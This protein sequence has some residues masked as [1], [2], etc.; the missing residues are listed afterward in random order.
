MNG[1]KKIMSAA[2]FLGLMVLTMYVIFRGQDLGE[3]KAAIVHIHK[4]Y[5]LAGAGVALFFV[6]A[7]GMMIWYLFRIIG[8]KG[9]LSFLSEIF[10]CGIFLF[11]HYAVSNGRTAYAVILYGKGRTRCRQ[12][13]GGA[14]DSGGGI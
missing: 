14:D 2:L 8:E 4:G 10:L 6:A 3:V 13:L 7:E 1:K 5:L 12:Q 11:R 9:F